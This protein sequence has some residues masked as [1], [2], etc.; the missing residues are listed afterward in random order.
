MDVPVSRLNNR[1]ALQLP[2][3]LPLGLV[4]VVGTVV[5][6]AHPA[7]SHGRPTFQLVD[8]GYSLNCRLSGRAF[9]ETPFNEGDTIRAGGHLV[10]DPRQATYY[11]IAR[12][13]ELLRERPAGQPS[14]TPILDD[15]RKRA[16]SASLA[17]ADLP[18]WVK[19]IAPP[20][21]RSELGL[22]PPSP[23]EAAPDDEEA[24]SEGE[25]KE[26]AGI[27]PELITF[28]SKAMDSEDEVE[29]TPEVIA[30]LSPTLPP[31]GT[32]FKTAYPYDDVT[33][34]PPPEQRHWLIGAAVLILVLI[35]LAFF[36]ILM[37]S[38]IGAI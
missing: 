4:F 12:D 28:L 3:E 31:N 6:L 5:N 9:T 34:V 29:L 2:A 35:I 15:V 10:F 22:L 16:A 30:K 23:E 24:E 13:I 32:Q 21:I 18:P 38:A 27:S 1:M 11:L 37:L 17:P 20:E 8:E 26:A 33:N 14:L 7:N 19:E 36:T 25:A